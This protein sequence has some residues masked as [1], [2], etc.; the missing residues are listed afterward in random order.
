MKEGWGWSL[1]RCGLLGFLFLFG[2]LLFCF[3]DLEA[4]FD[5]GV[6]VEADAVDAALDEEAGEV[7]EVAGSLAADADFAPGFVGVGGGDELVDESFDGVVAFV[8]EVGD[9]VAVA[10]EAEGELGEVVAADAEAV[11]D[12]GEL[13]GDDDVA[14]DFGHDVDLEVVFS[15]FEALFVHDFDDLASFVWG[16]AEGDHGFDV[17]EAHFVT[18][19]FEGFAFE[20]EGRLEFGVVIA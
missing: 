13:V 18:A 12:V 1:F 4:C 16:A 20:F 14:G 9:E 3:G 6:W 15:L 10:V 7:W 5:D 17:S 8:E 2:E 11:E 19:F